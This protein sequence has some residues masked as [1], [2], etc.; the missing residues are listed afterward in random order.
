MEV[1]TYVRQEKGTRFVQ[2]GIQP[3]KWNVLSSLTLTDS[4]ERAAARAAQGL[5]E[6]VGSKSS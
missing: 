2:K 1:L 6:G 4:L 5:R 3:A